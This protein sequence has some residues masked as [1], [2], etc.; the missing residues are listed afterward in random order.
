L[1]D[2][3]SGE[4][5]APRKPSRHRRGSTWG[6]GIPRRRR[7]TSDAWQIQVL[8]GLL[9]LGVAAGFL[10]VGLVLAVLT[11]TAT[12]SEAFSLVAGGIGLGLAILFTDRVAGRLLDYFS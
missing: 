2:S 5:A 12:G 6:Q 9:P 1:T 3:E 7:K 11:Y 10:A 8:S 4:T